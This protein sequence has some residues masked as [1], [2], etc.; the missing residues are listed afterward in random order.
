MIR[1]IRGVAVGVLLAVAAGAAA[2]QAQELQLGGGTVAAGLLLRQL[3]GEK[4]VL[5]IGAHPD[6][7]DTGLLAALVRGRGAR[8][9]YLSL[10]R[11]EG[12]QNLIG[13]ELDEALGVLRT[14]ELL[15]AR[16]LDGAQQFFTRA[17][18]FGYSKSAAETFREW[19]R[20]SIVGDVVWVM[21]VFRPQV[22]VAMFSGTPADGHGQHQVA[23]LVAREAFEAA[24]D[25]ARFPE[26]LA[27]GVR[28]WRPLKL[29]L[30]SWRE[31]AGATLSVET[32]EF[33]PLLGR[34]HY[35]LAMASRSRHR[36]QDM[37]RIQP[38][39]PQRSRLTL[40]ASRVTDVA[41]DTS[42]FAGIDT[43]L[44]ALAAELPA[45]VRERALEGVERYRA[46]VHAAVVALD[47]LH[48]ERAV[49]ALGRVVLEARDLAR[50][51]ASAGPAGE[52]FRAAM[53]D[54]LEEAGR[55]L[56]AAGSVV[57]DVRV[58][59]D[60]LVPGQEATVEV[61]LWN[62]GPFQVEAARARVRGRGVVP[63]P[64]RADASGSAAVRAG[65]RSG[66]EGVAVPPG[67]VRTWR[68]AVLVRQDPAAPY[69]SEPYYLWSPREGS[70]YRWPADPELRGR[71]FNPPVVEG[72]VEVE[73]M[74]GGAGGERVPVPVRVVVPATYRDADKSAGEFRRP[75]LVVPAVSV[76]VEPRHL[77]WPVGS[78][79]PRPITVTLRSESVEAVTGRVWLR[80]PD[81]WRSEPAWQ[82]F[83]LPGAGGRVALGFELYAPPGGAQGQF[84]AGVMVED[85]RGRTYTRGYTVV[86]YPHV[87]PVPL[88]TEAVIHIHAFPVA[89][90]EGRR[91]GYV[92]GAGDDGPEAIRQLGLPVE[93]L[94]S[95]EL[96]SGEPGRYDVIVL[97]VR[98]YEVRADLAAANA[99]VLD[100]V[101]RGG[102]VIV[103]Y[104][105]YEYVD[106]GFAPYPVAMR[107]PHDRVTDEAAP[108]T[109]LAPESP[110]FR[111]PNVITAADFEGWEQ[112]R[113][114][115]FLSEWDPRYTPLVETADAGEAPQRGALL[116]AMVGDGV[117]VYTGLS[118][119]RQLPAGVPG[120]YRLFANLL[121]LEPARW[122]AYLS[123]RGAP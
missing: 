72:E 99:R 77:V 102:V 38:A 94:G 57:L 105:K 80:L 4:R 71:P 10:S 48:P 85:S 76:R 19:P 81:G 73:V 21:R 12:G 51:A 119:F 93:L 114:L 49:P 28:P 43:A 9:A 50:L 17:Y 106:G 64:A 83:E 115:Y 113:G 70:L 104:N 65:V 24:G 90:A 74:V 112:E 122:R 61:E 91:V 88:F 5:V 54:R 108:V 20:D 29:Y 45:S 27:W 111:E 18:D 34:S 58:S 52:G 30:R 87:D 22:V 109:I 69:P 36:S 121:S 14:S 26:Q 55:A 41:T 84:R 53:G 16:R 117:Y 118:F 31:G 3:D 120:A 33:D 2:A 86:D 79:G 89:V 6:D 75:P 98:A 103:Q 56:L 25:P 7:E 66:A 68:F 101:R 92:M 11:G 116:V 40:L 100:Y 23:G 42:L 47:A 15:S 37:G 1:G 13:G 63:L 39:G 107:R 67:T 59:D 110:V 96:R 60:V 44:S 8:V 35:Q 123:G 62:G 78:R 97:G 46:A 82:A 32:G 95:E